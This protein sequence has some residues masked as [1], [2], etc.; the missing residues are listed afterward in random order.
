MAN[1]GGRRERRGERGKGGR[2]ASRGGAY[3]VGGIKNSGPGVRG[4]PAVVPAPR[5]GRSF[6][7]SGLPRMYKSAKLASLLVRRLLSGS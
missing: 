1:R 5:A 4:H 2:E 7:S 3:E 6:T